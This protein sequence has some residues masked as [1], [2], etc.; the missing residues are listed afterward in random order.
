MSLITCGIIKTASQKLKPSKTDPLLCVT[1]DF[2][3]NAPIILYDLLS[4]IMK[5]YFV[6][7]HVSDFLLI[8]TLVPIVNDKLSDIS[9]SNN[10]R[11]IAISSL[12]MTIFDWVI[13]FA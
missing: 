7:G 4:T 3:M 6:H 5:S 11:S 10:Y 9:S 1:S 12:V 8:S 2:F 13:I